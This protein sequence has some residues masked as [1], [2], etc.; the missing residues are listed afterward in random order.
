VNAQTT[1]P[2]ATVRRNVRDGVLITLASL[3]LGALCDPAVE[4]E[5][6]ALARW[7]RDAVP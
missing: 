4:G 3:S 6:R 5:L 2:A 7:V 1:R